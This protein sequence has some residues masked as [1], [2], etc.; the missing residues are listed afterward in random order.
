MELAEEIQDWNL[1]MSAFPDCSLPSVPNSL[2]T[3][4]QYSFSSYCTLYFLQTPSPVQQQHHTWSQ[5]YTGDP[6]VMEVSVTCP[7]LQA[8]AA[9]PGIALFYIPGL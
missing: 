9:M 1:R 7:Q 4:H 6:E 2:S 3:E 8:A 5:S